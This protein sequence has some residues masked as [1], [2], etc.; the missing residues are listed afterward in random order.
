MIEDLYED[1]W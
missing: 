1:S